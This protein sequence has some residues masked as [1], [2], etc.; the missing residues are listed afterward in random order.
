ME[1]TSRKTGMNERPAHDAS[2]NN[3]REVGGHPSPVV[4]AFQLVT[5]AEIGAHIT[6]AQTIPDILHVLGNVA[7]WVLTYCGCTLALVNAEADEFQIYQRLP[8]GEVSKSATTYTF[9]HGLI[10]QTLSQQQPVMIADTWAAPLEPA[11]RD[12]LAPCARSALF[13]PLI[14][15]QRVLGALNICA[16]R[17][18]AYGGESFGIGRLLALQVTS[19]VRNALLLEDLDGKENVILSLA[20]A[21]EAKDPYT[22]G[23]CQ[24][25]AHYAARLGGAL[26]FNQKQLANLRMAAILHD[27]GKIAVPE[28]ILNKPD[29]LTPHEYLVMQQHPLVG[30]T[31]CQPLR[32]MRAILSTI[33]HHHERWDGAGYP[34]HLA[35][36][37][38]PLDARII[39]I[40]DAYDAMTSDRPYRSGMPPERALAI[41]RENRGPQW[42]P[43]LID[44]FV[45]LVPQLNA[46]F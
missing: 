31:I 39:A 33:R 5:L 46:P 35:G 17:P 13:L 3:Q 10:G 40:V 2:I 15:Q 9:N 29:V 38:I 12:A 14:D 22:Q 41:L 25:L 4:P 42:D 43:A 27:V 11:D 26:D 32:S 34:D 44:L 24:R 1:H 28:A 7:R 16:A 18:H 36:D 45:P 6:S 21:I 20:L 8:S 30:E 37:Q 23:H 19:A